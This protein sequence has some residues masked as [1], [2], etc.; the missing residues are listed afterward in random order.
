MFYLCLVQFFHFQI[1]VKSPL[2]KNLI[3]EQNHNF[4]YQKKIESYQILYFRKIRDHF[5]FIKVCNIFSSPSYVTSKKIVPKNRYRSSNSEDTQSG[6]IILKII[7]Q[8][9]YFMSYHSLHVKKKNQ[10][11]FSRIRKKVKNSYYIY[12]QNCR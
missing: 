9:N 12:S 2:F 7:D 1:I 10:I 11:N 3:I 4:D 6:K 8:T 5:E